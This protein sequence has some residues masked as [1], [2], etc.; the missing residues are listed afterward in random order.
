MTQEQQAKQPVY[1]K[2]RERIEQIESEVINIKETIAKFDIESEKTQ[3][4]KLCKTT[5]E[6]FNTTVSK[7]MTALEE[8]FNSL[9]AQNNK[10]ICDETVSLRDSFQSL[11]GSTQKTLTE[12]LDSQKITFDT[13]IKNSE[14]QFEKQQ[15]KYTTE[16]NDLLQTIKS[17]LPN[18]TAVGLA[19][20]FADEKKSHKTLLYGY[21][22]AFVVI[23]ILM[24]SLPFIAFHLGYINYFFDID[25]KNIDIIPF[26][27]SSLRIIILE[28][29]LIW[30]ANIIAKKIQQQ[31]RIHEEY[32]HK[33][34]VAMTFVGMSKEA[35]DNEKLFGADHI[36]ELTI[37]FR[38]AVYM[39]PSNTLDKQI[40]TENPIENLAM[41]V[42]AL[43]LDTV[44]GIVDNIGKK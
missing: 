3:I 33:Y 39:N 37:G 43:G 12:F 10:K 20:A 5:E 34:T 9:T 18:A 22:F 19:K 26:L 35:K 4:N 16:Y 41:I 27:L 44:K 14:K 30:L 28:L 24:V 32:V 13:L 23:I 42:K 17:L 29:P 6:V 31:Q 40:K 36:Q 7:Q 1:L 11:T 38:D 25:G 2:N 21:N 15:S 8:K